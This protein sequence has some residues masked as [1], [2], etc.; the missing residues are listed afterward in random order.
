MSRSLCT[1][2]KV[3][4]VCCLQVNPT[5]IFVDSSPFK[6]AAI[7]TPELYVKRWGW[8]GDPRFVTCY[9]SQT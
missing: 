4:T 9:N 8:I 2:W 7:D 6:G 1:H 5:T 3:L